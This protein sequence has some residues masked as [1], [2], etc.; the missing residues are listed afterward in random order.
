VT[1]Y[2]RRVPRDLK[3]RRRLI[4]PARIVADYLRRSPGTFIWLAILLVTTLIMRNLPPHAQQRVIEWH[5]TNVHQLT[6]DPVRVLISSAL[7]LDGG[8]W[9]PY[10]ILYG[11]FHAPAERWLGS[12]RWL[13]VVVVA[14]VGATYISEGIVAYRIDHGLAPAS[15]RFV[16]DIGV[17]YALAG[18]QGVLSYLI[19]PL[20]RY[21]YIV[22]VAGFYLLDLAEHPDF[23]AVGHISAVLLGLICY[24]LTVG[25]EGEWDPLVTA[26]WAWSLRRRD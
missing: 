23:T 9:W 25:R 19:T 11:L 18:V 13:A 14:H 21:A 16:D 12:L 4:A 7:W 6:R 2:Q 15:E 8:H 26:R 3:A 24:P 5:S 17:S 1:G 22:G 20:W 10:V